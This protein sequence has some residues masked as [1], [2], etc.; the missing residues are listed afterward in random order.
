MKELFK[1]STSPV[2][3]FGR[4]LMILFV[5]GALYLLFRGV[6]DPEPMSYGNAFVYFA[7]LYA[8]SFPVQ[9]LLEVLKAK[10]L[11]LENG[12]GSYLYGFGVEL[13]IWLLFALL[14]PFTGD[15]GA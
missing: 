12:T 3:A 6:V 2:K 10:H 7:V 5:T 14:M 15:L 9:Y 8:V 1:N 4:I 11:H 13:L